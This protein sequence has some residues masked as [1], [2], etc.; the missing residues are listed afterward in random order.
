MFVSR[1]GDHRDL[2]IQIIFVIMSV[3][4]IV[5]SGLSGD[6]KRAFQPNDGRSHLQGN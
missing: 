1:D 3:S 6:L 5:F 2:M 4:A